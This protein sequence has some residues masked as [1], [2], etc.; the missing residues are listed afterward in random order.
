MSQPC[1]S[2]PTPQMRHVVRFK[3]CQSI[4]AARRHSGTAALS[5]MARRRPRRSAGALSL[6][7]KRNVGTRPQLRR[8]TAATT[9]GCRMCGICWDTTAGGPRRPASD[10]RRCGGARPEKRRRA[11]ATTSTTTITAVA[12]VALPRCSENFAVAQSA[13]TCA[14]SAGR[15]GGR[16]PQSRTQC[17]RCACGATGV[18]SARWTA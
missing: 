12:D 4:I 1:G 11:A 3:P 6:S 9:S 17:A 8:R 15:S 2:C 18:A 13:N 7:Q 10:R 14:A 5:G 16:E